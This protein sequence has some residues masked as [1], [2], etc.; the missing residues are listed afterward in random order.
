MMTLEEAVNTV[1]LGIPQSDARA[2]KA[3]LIMLNA[4]QMTGIEAE[5]ARQEV[6]ALNGEIAAMKNLND[7]SRYKCHPFGYMRPHPAGKFVK[8]EDVESYLSNPFGESYHG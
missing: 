5:G 4:L 8:L 3:L 6:E 1:T 2:H 7:I